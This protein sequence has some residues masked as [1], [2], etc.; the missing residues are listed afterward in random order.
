MRLA[1]FPKTFGLTEIKTGYFPHL[2][3]TPANQ[4][5]VGTY[6]PA[7]MYIPVQTKTEQSSIIVTTLRK[8][9]ELSL[10][11]DVKWKNIVAATWIFSDEAVPASERY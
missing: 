11:S 9:R 6:F 10:T 4:N 2:A 8:I 3:N 5:Y 1:N 7:E